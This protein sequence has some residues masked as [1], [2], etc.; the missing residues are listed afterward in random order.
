MKLYKILP[1]LAVIVCS[2]KNKEV[3]QVDF[4]LSKQVEAVTLMGD[5]I[6]SPELE[7]NQAFKNYQAAKKAY[8]SNP[9]N[10]DSIIWFGRRTAYLGYFKD[11]ISIYSKGIELH[12]TEPQ[13]YRHRG[14]RYISTRQYDKAIADFEK[15]VTLIEGKQ[16]NVEPDGLPNSRNIPLSTLHGNIWYHLGLAYY[17]KGD[18][19]NALKA[20]NNRSIT[21][22]YPDNLV[23]GGYW[24][25]M[26]NRRLG[27]EEAANT[28]IENITS[29]M[30]II[31]NM[32]YHTMCLLFKGTINKDSLN[33]DLIG[34][35]S[36]DVL[37]YGLGNWY[38]FEKQDT[39]KAKENYK[40]LLE[41]G[42]K[43]SFAYLAAESDWKRLLE[44]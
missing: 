40:R 3:K 19:K 43:F 38:L 13:L 39:L 33:T 44:K 12:P 36:S 29:D 15:A 22:K 30:D 7:E 37:S 21:E 24:Q 41:N 5:S 8:E 10:I 2:C 28:A 9:Q 31:E 11:A 6:Y 23:S 16:D 17:L 27:N 32:S 25:Y 1:L 18:I 34:T 20:Y 26:I 35:S 4:E 14:H 42:N